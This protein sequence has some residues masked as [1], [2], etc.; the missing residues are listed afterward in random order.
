MKKIFLVLFL[1]ILLFTGCENKEE[2]EKNDY[3][4]MKSQL[5]SHKEF[6]SLE[7]LTCD[8]VVNIDRKDEE[9][10]IYEVVLSKPKE[11]MNNIKAVLVHNYYTEDVFPTIGL[12]DDTK[13]L[14]VNSQDSITLKGS[15]KTDKDIDN[16]N[17]M[18][19]LLIRYTT[20]DGVKKDIYY[21][22]TK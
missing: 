4:D 20:D 8:I 19:K 3:L 13:S 10:V 2:N 1:S 16:L 14:F 15:I 22:T 21:K 7:E 11:N 5:L 18:L 9:K 12:F 17:L 6:I